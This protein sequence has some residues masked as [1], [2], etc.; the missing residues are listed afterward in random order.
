MITRRQICLNLGLLPLDFFDPQ[1]SCSV[2]GT[3]RFES[4]AQLAYLCSAAL[5]GRYASRKFNL[6]FGLLIILAFVSL[7]EFG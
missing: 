3:H 5:D 6:Q 1:S 4:V 7:G 2:G